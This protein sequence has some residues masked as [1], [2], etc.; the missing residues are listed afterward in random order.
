[1][2]GSVNILLSDTIKYLR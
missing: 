1:M 2:R